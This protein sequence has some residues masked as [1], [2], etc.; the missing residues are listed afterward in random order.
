MA[1]FREDFFSLHAGTEA[2]EGLPS[3]VWKDLTG[4]HNPLTSNPSY[5]FGINWNSNYE[6]GL[7]TQHLCPSSLLPAAGW[8]EARSGGCYSSI[9]MPMILV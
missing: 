8:K 1:T 4:L 3:L 2:H 9:L 7:I 5:T 6:P